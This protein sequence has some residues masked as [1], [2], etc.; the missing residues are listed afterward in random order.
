MHR[1]VVP[2]RRDAADRKAG[3][4]A[5]LVAARLAHVGTQFR[6]VDAAIAGAE[7]EERRIGHDEDE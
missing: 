7:T 2:E 6:R 5:Y 3:R 4:L 1:A